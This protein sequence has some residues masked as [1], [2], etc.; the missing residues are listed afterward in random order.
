MYLSFRSG[1]NCNQT[2]F[3]LTVLYFA[4]SEMSHSAIL[5]GRKGDEISVG[6]KR[7]SNGG[8]RLTGSEREM[9]LHCALEKYILKEE[10]LVTNGYPR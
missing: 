10:E 6:I 8:L 5:A 3:L 2:T 9:K 4:S 7:N 1:P